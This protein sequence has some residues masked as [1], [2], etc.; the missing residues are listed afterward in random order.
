MLTDRSPSPSYA[1]TCVR[2]QLKCAMMEHFASRWQPTEDVLVANIYVGNLSFDV[3]ENDLQAVFEEHGQ[4]SSVN[5]IKDRETGRSRGFA[6]VEMP[7]SQ[8]AR[9]AIEVKH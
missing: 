3:T 2:C 4:V 8:Q 7:D 5:I 9:Q 1:A 6:F